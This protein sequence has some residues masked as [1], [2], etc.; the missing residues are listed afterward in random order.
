MGVDPS[1]LKLRNKRV[2]N[3]GEGR[4]QS[5]L[6]QGASQGFFCGL[7]G[8]KAGGCLKAVVSGELSQGQVLLRLMHPGIR[9]RI[10][11]PCPSS[12]WAS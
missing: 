7:G 6:Q 9:A 3:M 4:F 8:V 11:W 5:E 10:D 1:V 12:G 2:Q